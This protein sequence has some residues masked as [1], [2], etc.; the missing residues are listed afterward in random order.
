L[1]VLLW[2]IALPLII[3]ADIVTYIGVKK[4]LEEKRNEELQGAWCCNPERRKQ[5]IMEMRLKT[6][7]EQQA[8]LDYC[9]NHSVELKPIIVLLFSVMLP[10]LITLLLWFFGAGYR[11]YGY[12]L[13]SS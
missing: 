4:D 9:N 5:Q 3:V 11:W 12:S 8:Y 13:F 7:D 6:S 1:F 2:Y 10:I